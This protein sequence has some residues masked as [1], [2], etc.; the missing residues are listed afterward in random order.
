VVG[1]NGK[2]YD[3]ILK[4]IDK[5]VK[6]NLLISGIMNAKLG[7]QIKD[8]LSGWMTRFS[9]WDILNRLLNLMTFAATVHNAQMLSNNLVTTLIGTI[10]NVV[11]FLE[12]KDSE[13]KGYDVNELIK[14]SIEQFLKNALG[15]SAFNNLSTNWK[16]A[17]RIYQSA[18]NLFNS[19]LS[20]GDITTQALQ[21]VTGQTSK[22]GNALRAWGTV[23]EKAYTW[24]NPNPNFNNPYLMKLNS[25]ND[26]ASIVEEVSQQPQTV[27][28]AKKEVEDNAA[29]LAKDIGQAVD[30]K[31]GIKFP[32]AKK[33]KDEQDTA[34]SN[35]EAKDMERSDLESDVELTI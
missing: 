5:N 2:N 19:M 25:L 35:S 16:N 4:R 22:I 9:K 6:S 32:E 18:G 7:N 33:V 29:Q 3:A 31:D 21:L 28:E 8:G 24:M 27:K 30:G 26:T 20:F 17:N 10:Q 11:N 23:G 13:G 1:G 14:Q 15:E 34:K 12:L